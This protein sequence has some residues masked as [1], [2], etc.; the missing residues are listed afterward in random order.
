M[1]K[2][3]ADKLPPISG[4]FDFSFAEKVSAQLKAE[5]WTPT[6]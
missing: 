1:L 2:V 4:V 3:A 6:P 5:G